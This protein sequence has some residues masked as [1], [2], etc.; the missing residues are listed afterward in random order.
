MELGLTLEERCSMIKG[1]AHNNDLMNLEIAV[2]R[3]E[4]LNREHKLSDDALAHGLEA[5]RMMLDLTVPVSE[6]EEDELLTASLCHVLTENA[7]IRDTCEL[8]VKR[9]LRDPGIFG[10]VNLITED[11]TMSEAKQRAFF[12][13]LH[14]NR[15]A[16]LVK[17]VDRSVHTEQLFDMPLWR[18]RAFIHETRETYFPLCH[19]MK[20]HDPELI[21]VVSILLEKM[22][23]LLD[24]TDLLSMKYES[25]ETAIM[26]EI[27]E[28]SEEN[29]R[30]RGL[31]SRLDEEE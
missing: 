2:M 22:R 7:A 28:L 14:G 31:L 13:H 10:I 15:L 19:W 26:N 6:R 20:E 29:A 1:Y 12:E 3:M 5:M 18:A 9:S 27:E 21:P 17:L 24:V 16:V 23:C 30:L 11:P 25:R 8:A 4:E